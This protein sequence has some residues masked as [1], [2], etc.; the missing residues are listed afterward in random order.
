MIAA[1]VMI[2]MNIYLST[3]FGWYFLPILEDAYLGMKNGISLSLGTWGWELRT[4]LST[5]AIAFQLF[6]NFLNETQE[7]CFFTNVLLEILVTFQLQQ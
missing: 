3:Q 6:S 4:A 5:R 2:Y 1:M 7:C